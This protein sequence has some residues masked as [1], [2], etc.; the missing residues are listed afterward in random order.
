M[1]LGMLGLLVMVVLILIR[2][3]F[4]IFLSPRTESLL[5]RNRAGIQNTAI[6]TAEHTECSQ[7]GSGTAEG[8]EKQAEFAGPA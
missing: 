3:I 7:V 1:L 2:A 8:Y 6:Q 5:C 4:F